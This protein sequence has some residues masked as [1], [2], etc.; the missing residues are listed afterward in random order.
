MHKLLKIYTSAP[1]NFFSNQYLTG[2]IWSQSVLAQIR[3]LESVSTLL[4]T[5]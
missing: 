1:D 3:I 2:Q 5:W 4:M